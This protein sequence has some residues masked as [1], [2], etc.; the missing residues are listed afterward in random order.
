MDSTYLQCIYALLQ[1]HTCLYLEI[2]ILDVALNVGGG[3]SNAI[4]APTS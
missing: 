2:R 4:T 3:H 1:V